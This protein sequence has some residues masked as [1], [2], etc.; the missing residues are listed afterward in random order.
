MGNAEDSRK[1]NLTTVVFLIEEIIRNH[2]INMLLISLMITLIF[3]QNRKRK[4]WDRLGQSVVLDSIPDHVRQLDRLVRVT[5]SAC[6]DNL[7]MDRNT[8]GRLCRILRDRVGLVDQR[9]V[10]VE[11]QLAMFLCVLAHHKKSL[12]VGHNFMRSS[13]TVSKYIHTVLHGVLTL[14]N[15]FLVK[16][17]P[18]DEA[19]TD[20]T[21]KWFKGCL[22]AL[23]G[24]YINVRVPIADVPRYRN[25]KGH[26]TT[27]TLAVCDPQ[28]RF[29]YLLPGWEGSAA[30]S[31]ILRDAI[32]RPLG[33]KVPK[34]C[35]YL[36]DQAYPNA[37]G[38][39]TPYKGVRYHLKEWGVGRQ[40]PQT[41]EELFNLRHSKARNVIER[42]FAVLKMRWGILRSASFYPIDV[43]TGLIIACF[44]LHN[45]IRSEMV[46]DAVEAELVNEA[47]IDDETA[48][49]H[50]LCGDNISSVEPSALW[51]QK[52]DDLAMEMWGDRNNGQV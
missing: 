6:V 35:Y 15:L 44:L 8:F 38:F 30:D 51:T 33:L 11:E 34:G 37:E 23:D 28:L 29:T 41:P 7:R 12:I 9:Q 49:D 22:G 52:R 47:D 13:Q 16:P 1:N 4:R 10:T 43:Q 32:S 25:R 48:N 21:W 31:R 20:R 26:I 46:V 39:L 42:S 2:Q 14:H 18:I 45:Y 19:C 50:L 40:A 3:P 36:C 27:N 17:I 5:D 24:T